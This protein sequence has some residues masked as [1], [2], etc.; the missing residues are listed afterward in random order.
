MPEVVMQP[1]APITKEGLPA[2]VEV[3]AEEA[4]AKKKRKEVQE[5]GATQ[6]R[7]KELNVPVAKGIQI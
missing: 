2:D 6:R 4:Q 3:G 5:R 1:P 7:R